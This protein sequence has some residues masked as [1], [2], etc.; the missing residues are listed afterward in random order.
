MERERPGAKLSFYLGFLRSKQSMTFV[1]EKVEYLFN[2]CPECGGLT[3][4]DG[5]CSFCRMKGRVQERVQTT[6][7]K[8]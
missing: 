8:A 7:R 1:D 6:E 3:T 4:S 2:A 5:S